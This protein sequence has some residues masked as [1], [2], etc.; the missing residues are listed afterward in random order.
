MI[1]RNSLLVIFALCLLALAAACGGGT[2]EAESEGGDQAEETA[3]AGFDESKA[4]A[5]KGKV[6]YAATADPD[7]PIKMDAD[8]A[9]VGLHSTPVT[10]E[11]V[12]A[13]DGNLANVFVYVKA[14]LPAGMT[15]DPPAEKKLL[16][17]QG[18][19]YHPH[20]SGIQTGQTLV[21]RNSDST[22]HN[23]HAMPEKNA[24]FNQGQPVQGMENEKT[25]DQEEVMVP[26][27]CD[28]HPWMSSYMGVLPHPYFAV[29]G[30]DGAF[31]L[32]KLPPG[33]YTVEAWH[34]ELGTKTQQVTVPE[35]GTVEAN[36]DFGS[37]PT[38]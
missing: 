8:P 9:C 34:E 24:E 16:D 18:C 28:V 10:T 31:A 11:K 35:S 25:F 7:T 6:A 20:V 26:F 14:G 27:K 17:Q 21:I 36:F 32:E 23:I 5:V 38:T 37:A 19:M 22:L 29:T 15:F 33:T 1:Q 3:P 13:N 30:E 2:P 4:G 12:V